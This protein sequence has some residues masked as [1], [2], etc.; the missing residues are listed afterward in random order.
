LSRAVSKVV[1]SCTP[2]EISLQLLILK[3]LYLLFTTHSTREYFYTNDLHVLVDILLRN[4]L[5]LPADAPA[6]VSLR[7]T[8]LRVLHPLLAHT[9]LRYLPHYKRDQLRRTLFILANVGHAHF[10]PADD[11]TVRLVGRCLAVEWLRDADD[12]TPDTTTGGHAAVARRSLGMALPEGQ[13]SSL[14]VVEVAVQHEKPGVLMPS[15]HRDAP[16]QQG[17]LGVEL[18][19]DS[20][21]V[22]LRSPFADDTDEEE[23]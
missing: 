14:S 9:Q 17:M 3:L 1:D 11:I 12:A 13:D 16:R 5:D 22:P 19:S 18:N 8:Y 23:S 21:D 7:H 2:G 15:K 10:A 6:A 4:L 20:D